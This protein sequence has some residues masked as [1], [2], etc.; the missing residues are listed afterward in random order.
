MSQVEHTKKHNSIDSE[1]KSVKR[2]ADHQNPFNSVFLHENVFGLNRALWLEVLTDQVCM[3][4]LIDWRTSATILL[5]LQ[6]N[7]WVVLL[8]NQRRKH[9]R[10][11]AREK[12]SYN[13]VLVEGN[14]DD[15]FCYL[16]NCLFCFGSLK[17][18]IC[19][20]KYIRKIITASG[21]HLK[22]RWNNKKTRDKWS[23]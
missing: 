1:S 2:N 23:P 17:V 21:D 12:A 6:A 7:E 4:V 11:K 14:I 8:S 15:W 19:M 9:R 5:V 18:E 20:D 13:S 10:P 3:I 16:L 22:L